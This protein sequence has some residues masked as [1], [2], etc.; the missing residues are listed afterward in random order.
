M[1]GL[2]SVRPPRFHFPDSVP[3]DGPWDWLL[4]P[5]RA[6][7]GKDPSTLIPRED[8]KITSGLRQ[9]TIW[10]LRL[11]TLGVVVPGSCVHLGG[12]DGVAG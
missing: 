9:T 8:G 7:G 10:P 11:P 12:E 1:Q 6:A 5:S 4:V 3:W 2:G